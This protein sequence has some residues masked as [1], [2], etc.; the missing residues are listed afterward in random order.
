[1]LRTSRV[2]ASLIFGL[3]LAFFVGCGDGKVVPPGDH[4]DA[5]TQD[6]GN[7]GDGGAMDSGNTEVDGGGGADLGVGDTGAGDTGGGANPITAPARTWTWIDF[8]ESAC[9]NGTATGIGINLGDDRKNLMIFMNGGGACW[10]QITCTIAN[11]AT[12]GPFGQAQFTA[13]GAALNGGFFDRNN[14][15]NIFKD[16]SYVFVPYCTGDVHAGDNV[17]NYGAPYHH[18]GHKNMVAFLDRLAATF[19]APEKVLMSGSSAGGFGAALNY[20]AARDRWATPKMYLLDDSGP[21]LP[22][23]YIPAS[24]RDA[25]YSAWNIGEILDP[26]CGQDCHTDFSIAMRNLAQKYPNDRMALLSSL[27][28][29]V[30]RGFVNLSGPEFETGLRQLGTDV[31]DPLPNFKYFFITGQSHTMLGN[32]SGFNSNG[33]NLVDW[34]TQELTDD[35]NWASTKP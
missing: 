16:W 30:I 5:S 3:G 19:T 1:M 35:P 32:P 24:E 2:D 12:H 28:D 11:T 15:N 34:V 26:L 21:A 20:V 8:P 9:D 14:A 18:T 27:Q 10:D 6:S 33:H 7:G 17:A 25:W 4:P 29:N 23:N 22:G 31:L 13:L